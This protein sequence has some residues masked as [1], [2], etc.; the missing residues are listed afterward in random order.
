MGRER[1]V[2]G[3]HHGPDAGLAATMHRLGHLR[4]GWIKL[5]HQAQQDLLFHWLLR[6]GVVRGSGK[7]QNPQAPGGQLAGL[8]QP[9]L[10]LGVIQRFHPGGRQPAVTG[11]QQNF[12]SPFGEQQ[13]ART[14]SCSTQRGLQFPV[15]V[16]HPDRHPLALGTEGNLTLAVEALA[17]LLRPLASLG[18]RHHQG[19][20]GGIAQHIPTA[21]RLALEFGIT[22]EGSCLEQQVHGAWGRALPLGEG[23]GKGRRGQGADGLIALATDGDGLSARAQFLHHLA[24]L[25]EGARLVRTN[26]CD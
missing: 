1:M 5:G 24:V 16:A 17:Q 26:H 11:A 13:S 9:P 4:S 7:S 15:R 14:F 23:D 22:A 25:G 12:W 2:A 20:L 10:A 3:D 18:C 19:A 8:A 21:F 6:T